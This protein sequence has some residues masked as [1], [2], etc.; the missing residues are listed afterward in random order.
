VTE[1][2]GSVYEPGLTEIEVRSGRYVDVTAPQADRIHLDDIAHALSN[3]CRYTGHSRTFYSVAEH[4]VLVADRLRA[5]DY[6]PVVAM[7]GL[8]H[9]DAEAYLGDVARPLKIALGE[10]YRALGRQMHAVICNAVEIAYPGA[11]G[12]Q[13]V[14]DADMW[15]LAVEARCLMQSRG[16]GWHGLPSPVPGRVDL[17]L[18]PNEARRTYLW[19]HDKLTT[20]IAREVMHR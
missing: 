3:L 15:A 5:L 6:S 4:A 16:V 7:A 19:M 9:D 2:Y 18:Q 12:W 13:A 20:E 1:F 17:G 10:G 8:H 11:D 14:L